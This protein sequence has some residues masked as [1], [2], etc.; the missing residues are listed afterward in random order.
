MI[1]PFLFAYDFFTWFRNDQVQGRRTNFFDMVLSLEHG[2]KKIKK[3]YYT[4]MVRFG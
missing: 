1:H 4:T 3:Y 2:I